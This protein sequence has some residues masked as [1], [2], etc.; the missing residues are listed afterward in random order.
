MISCRFLLFIKD[1]SKT[2]TLE[3]IFPLNISLEFS[4]CLTL[5]SGQQLLTLVKTLIEE[6]QETCNKISQ[7]KNGISV[8]MFKNKHVLFESSQMYTL[9][10]LINF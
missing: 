10:K 5:L 6:I 7:T 3:D 4:R 9:N 8:C 2:F 1:C